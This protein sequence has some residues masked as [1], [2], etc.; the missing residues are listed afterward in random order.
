[1]MRRNEEIQQQQQQQQQ[2]HQQQ[3][4]L[5]NLSSSA[6]NVDARSF[7]GQDQNRHLVNQ[8]GV[9]NSMAVN[10]T[11][12]DQNQLSQVQPQTSLNSNRSK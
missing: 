4:M 9:K 7:Q 1:M 8:D 2:Q 5:N 3:Q 6:L 12:A 11:Q 10:L